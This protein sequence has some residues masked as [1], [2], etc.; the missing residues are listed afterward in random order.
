MKL[1]DLNHYFPINI[2]PIKSNWDTYMNVPT[3][4]KWE[5]V[6]SII[7][8]VNNDVLPVTLRTFYLNMLPYFV[9]NSIHQHETDQMINKT[10][11]MK[12]SNNTPKP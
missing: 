2:E 6:K 12:K 8:I 3:N 10:I 9:I 5:E 4:T 7:D 1:L 11:W